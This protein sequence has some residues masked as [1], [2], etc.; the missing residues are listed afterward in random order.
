MGPERD[1]PVSL[2]T[3]RVRKFYDDDVCKYFLVGTCPYMLF[4]NSKSDLGAHI[5]IHDDACKTEWEKLSQE[6]KD[7]YGYEAETLRL[8]GDLVAQS[9]RLVARNKA[10]VA[11]TEGVHKLT[12]DEAQRLVDIELKITE[13]TRKAESLGEEGK[14]DEAQEALAAIEE[15]NREKKGIHHA[16]GG[17]EKT[18][19]VCEVSGNFL[20]STDN[21]DRLRAH[22]EGKVY[23]GWKTVRDKYTEMTEAFRK[24]GRSTA[25]PAQPYRASTTP[26]GAY[27]AAGTGGGGGYSGGG[28]GYRGGGGGGYRGGGGGGGGYRGGGAGDRGGG[29]GGYRSGYGGG[30]GGNYRSGYGGGGGG[31]GGG[32]DRRDS[33]GGGGYD[34]RDGGGGGYDRDSRGGGGGYDRGRQYERSYDRGGSRYDQRSRSPPRSSYRR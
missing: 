13:L 21:E 5:L 20:S 17:G 18:M 8:L 29:G 32:Y 9:D 33:R 25:G 27:M 1:V 2:R 7:K 34:R 23:N 14:V 6:E 3:N 10:R 4:R 16:R 26:Q 28:G 30:G 24:A 31:G 19:M 11:E 12:D 22:F 15:C